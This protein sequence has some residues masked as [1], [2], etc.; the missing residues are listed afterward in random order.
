MES[1]PGV[2][3]LS[4]FLRRKIMK[5]GKT[6]FNLAIIATLVMS[7]QTAQA[8]APHSHSED[9]RSSGNELKVDVATKQAR[10]NDVA[11]QYMLEEDGTLYRM[12]GR[13]KCAITTKVSSFKVSSHP[14]DAA[15]IYFEKEGDLYVL[16]NPSGVSRT[17][18]PKATT[19]KIM[20]RVKEYSVISNTNTTIVNAALSKDGEFI[21]WDNTDVV[22]RTRGTQDVFGVGVSD[23]QNNNNFGVKGKPF[24]SYA[25]FAI[26]RMGNV[27][28]VQGTQPG[29]S[30]WEEGDYRS[31][32][33]FKQKHKIE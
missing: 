29:K 24:Q 1:I 33:Q 21:A 10:A 23:Y 15:M 11:D 7:Y 3:T 30:K 25:I 8:A 19:K 16:N 5:V 32:K 6:F 13:N 31:I 17:G 26:D 12:V 18:C 9:S 28:K 22:L 27:L 4:V 2:N 14:K 20:D